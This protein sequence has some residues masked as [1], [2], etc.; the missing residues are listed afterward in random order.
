MRVDEISLSGPFTVILSVTPCVRQENGG[1]N[2][3][4]SGLLGPG[5]EVEEMGLQAGQH[6]WKLLLWHYEAILAPVFKM[7]WPG[8]PRK[9]VMT[10]AVLQT[11][12][13]AGLRCQRTPC[14]RYLAHRPLLRGPH[15]LAKYLR[16][17]WM[18]AQWP[19]PFY[20][21]PESPNVERTAGVKC[22]F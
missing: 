10:K 9:L 4:V 18:W 14:L 2:S 17:P 19:G 20:Q 5:L 7:S 8:G 13:T 12:F 21:C 6:P 11:R 1:L 22:G 3:I 16:G 15:K